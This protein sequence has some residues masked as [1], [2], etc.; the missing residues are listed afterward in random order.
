MKNADEAAANDQTKIAEKF[1]ELARSNEKAIKE[2]Y[3]A[4]R[5]DWGIDALV[6]KDV[7]NPQNIVRAVIDSLARVSKMKKKNCWNFCFDY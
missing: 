4:V 5:S 7:S 2:I 3:E 6:G 1:Q